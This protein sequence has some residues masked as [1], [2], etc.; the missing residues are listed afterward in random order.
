MTLEEKIAKA[1]KT[2]RLAA[3]MSKEYYGKPLVI[4][5][6]GGK[7]SDV[8]LHLAEKNLKP[9]EFEVVNSHTSV[10][11]PETVY[12]IRE[13]FE[14]IRGGGIKATVLIPRDKDGKHITMWNLIEYEGMP[15]TQ[16]VRY[17]CRILKETS[18]PNRIC[19]V[20]IRAAESS[21]RKG[22][23][24]FSIRAEK[25]ADALHFS[26]E[27]AEEVFKESKEMQD[28]VWDCTLIKRM[29]EH[30]DIL[31]NPIY[32]WTDTEIWQYIRDEGI[33]TNCLYE[34]GYWRVGCI[35]CPMANYSL[36]MKQF[37]EYPTYKRAYIHAFDKMLE[38]RRKEGKETKWATGQ[39]VFDWWI[40][41]YE[42][43]C[44]GQFEFDL[45]KYKEN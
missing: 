10:D 23:D 41:E 15:P 1:G 40:K 33:Q 37:A 29:K 28:D 17:C 36:K 31:V 45:E 42:H 30:G 39:E 26:Q 14:R 13:V 6:S 38:K 19:A 5:Y 16:L 7:D 18:I 32:E 9:D 44:K 24:T 22:K 4:T 25:K 20:G 35:G 12:H 21:N 3:D 34:R 11:A 27:H 8:L 2:L 43:N